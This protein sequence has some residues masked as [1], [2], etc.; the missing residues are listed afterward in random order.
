MSSNYASINLIN[1]INNRV[2]KHIHQV[3]GEPYKENPSTKYRRTIQGPRKTTP[4]G[5]F[6]AV[7]N[8]GH[9]MT[10]AVL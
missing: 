6:K 4:G 7:G 5:N 10:I 9:F 1:D 2:L 3:L 8:K